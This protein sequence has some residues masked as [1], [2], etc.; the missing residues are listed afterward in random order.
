ML[1]LRTL[2]CAAAAA[3]ALLASPGG[4]PLGL[5]DEHEILDI[6]GNL[7][8]V[9]EVYLAV[10]E[11]PDNPEATAATARDVAQQILDFLRRAGYALAKVE[12]TAVGGR[13]LVTL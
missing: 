8:L 12:A 10:V 6:E 13:I 4:S 3:L 1:S 2:S 7:V 11:L 5:A 9:D